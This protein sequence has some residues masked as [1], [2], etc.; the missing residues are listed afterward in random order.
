MTTQ[1][2]EATEN[3]A[4]AIDWQNWHGQQQA[5]LA[6][7]HGFLAVTALHWLT[8]TPQRF[9]DAPGA[10]ST[11]PGGVIVVLDD[12]EEL[13]IDGTSAR[14]TYRFG[15]IP[16][17]GGVEAVWGEAVVEVAKRGG[18]HIVRPRHPDN[19]LRTG[20]HGTP[21]YAPDPKWVVV[22]SY[23]AFAE[24]RPTTVGAAVE[25][26][27]HVYAAPG[28]VE[29]ELNGQASA[30]TAFPGK[31]P[32]AL[33]LLFTDATSG[34]TT[35]AANRVLQLPPPAADGT[36]TLDFNQAV[37]LPC[38]YTDLATCPLPPAE[39]RLPIA[40]EAGE[41]IPYERR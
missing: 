37:N 23:T 29:F 4:F 38:A 19:P 35:Y 30:L 20:F 18:H 6:D 8:T 32:G 17:R 11:G 28:R 24:P 2:A 16:E 9:P 12:G 36:V 3:D 10:W 5:R 40:V 21:A 22:G 26:L 13:V 34:V 1:A 33:T 31:A 25:G 41:Q 14:G 7:P 39:N 15:I 27:E